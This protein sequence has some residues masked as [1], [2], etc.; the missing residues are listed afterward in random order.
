MKRYS[1]IQRGVNFNPCSECVSI[2]IKDGNANAAFT[3]KAEPEIPQ[4][5]MVA[6]PLE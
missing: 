2:A 5:E 1:M 4:S 3:A 6:T